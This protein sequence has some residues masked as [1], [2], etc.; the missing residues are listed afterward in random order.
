LDRE[1]ERNREGEDDQKVSQKEGEGEDNQIE[2][3]I[4]SLL[5]ADSEEI[6]AD[7]DSRQQ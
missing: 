5:G 6:V 2:E 1:V 3:C 7:D 4:T